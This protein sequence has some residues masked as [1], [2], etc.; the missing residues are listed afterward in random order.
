MQNARRLRN[1]GGRDS[2][3]EFI[4]GVKSMLAF[5][6]SHAQCAQAY[7]RGRACGDSSSARG[8]PSRRA[9]QIGSTLSVL[10]YVEMIGLRTEITKTRTRALCATR[11]RSH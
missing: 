5:C 1:G 2:R 6:K 4:D 11:A 9:P 7:E 8:A 10:Y 3:M